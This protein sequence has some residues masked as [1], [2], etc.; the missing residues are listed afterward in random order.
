MTTRD[1]FTDEEWFRV[2]S[3]PWRVAMGMIEADQSG[4]F[5][6]GRELQAVQN[7]FHRAQDDEGASDLV[8]LVARSVAD[9]NEGDTGT[10]PPDEGAGGSEDLPGQALAALAALGPVLDAKATGAE[11]AD[12]RAWLVSLASIAATAAK[13]GLAGIAGRKVSAA[14]QAYLDRLRQVLAG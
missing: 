3:A 12:Y 4:T 14:E 8:R 7:E 2:R 1:D 5:A 6:A 11:A 9:E 10:P 13:E